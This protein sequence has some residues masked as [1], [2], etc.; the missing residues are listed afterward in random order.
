VPERD[1]ADDDPA[2]VE[3]RQDAD[4]CDIDGDRTEHEPEL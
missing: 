2:L 4:D 1:D 3:H